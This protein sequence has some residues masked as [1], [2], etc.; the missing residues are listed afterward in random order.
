MWSDLVVSF[1]NRD[2]IVAAAHGVLKKNHRKNGRF[3]GISSNI[4]ISGSEGS[5]S[6]VASVT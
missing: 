1:S 3:S 6:R 4:R 2:F 5:G